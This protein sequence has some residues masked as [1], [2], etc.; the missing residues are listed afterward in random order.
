MCSG[1]NIV[2]SM[3]LGKGGIKFIVV[4]VDNF[5]KWV[6]AKPQSTIRVTNITKFLWKIVVC[7]FGIPPTIITDNG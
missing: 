1:V 6:E 7:K 3:P 4:A 5:T 2:G